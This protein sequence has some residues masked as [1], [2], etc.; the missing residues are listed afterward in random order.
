MVPAQHLSEEVFGGSPASCGIEQEIQRVASRIQG[1]I[2]V[3][4]PTSNFIDLSFSRFLSWVWL[5]PERTPWR[6]A[7]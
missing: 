3:H 4:P 5:P 7:E 1:A 6:S 2:Q